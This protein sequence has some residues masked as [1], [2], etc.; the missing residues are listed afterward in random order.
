MKKGTSFSTHWQELDS[1]FVM[2]ESRALWHSQRAQQ[3]RDCA[4][5]AQDRF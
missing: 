4:F 1:I 5:G 2:S 3:S